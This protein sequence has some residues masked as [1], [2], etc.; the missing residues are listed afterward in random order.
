MIE[1]ILAYNMAC[2]AL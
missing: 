1:L 2:N